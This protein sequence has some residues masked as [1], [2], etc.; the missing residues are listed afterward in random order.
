[1]KKYIQPEVEIIKLNIAL[2]LMTSE[3]LGKNDDPGD[4]VETGDILAPK[5]SLF[6]DEDN[7]EEVVY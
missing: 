2:P 7:E 1:M 4:E 5:W 6:D 3:D